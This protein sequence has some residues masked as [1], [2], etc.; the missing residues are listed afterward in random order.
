MLD[1]FDCSGDETS[2]LSCPHS[3]W[4]VH[5]CD[6][7]KE[8]AGVICINTVE[9]TPAHT[10]TNIFSNT[11]NRTGHLEMKLNF[12]FE[13]TDSFQYY[14]ENEASIKEITSL[15]SLGNI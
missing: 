2:L 10:S 3:N 15:Q 8:E 1:D 12:K 6:K 14:F 5:N 4:G 9:P 13:A 11:N 7:R